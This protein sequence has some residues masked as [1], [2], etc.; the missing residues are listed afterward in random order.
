MNPDL[1]RRTASACTTDLTP[2]LAALPLDD[3]KSMLSGRVNGSA[4]RSLLFLANVSMSAA[5]ELV[6]VRL[7]RVTVK[8]WS[9]CNVNLLAWSSTIT[10]HDDRTETNSE[11]RLSRE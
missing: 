8:V 5:H 3:C 9:G 11:T 1:G 7:L 10:K 2:A 4:T 6:V